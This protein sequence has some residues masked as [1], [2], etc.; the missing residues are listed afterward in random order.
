MA[1]FFVR[2]VVPYIGEHR[3]ISWDS[4]NPLCFF[5]E[6][7]SSES[8]L[9]K[10]EPYLPPQDPEVKKQLMLQDRRDEYFDM[11]VT[12]LKSLDASGSVFGIHRRA[13]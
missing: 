7:G 9:E 3:W 12:E 1:K 10:I 11:R 2:V 5:V 6:C 8:V 4:Q 13:L